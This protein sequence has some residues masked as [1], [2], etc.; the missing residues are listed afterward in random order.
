[1]RLIGD[2]RVLEPLHDRRG[3]AAVAT[4]STAPE[5]EPTFSASQLCVIMQS[6][7]LSCTEA[8]EVDDR[9][10]ATARRLTALRLHIT[11]TPAN[12]S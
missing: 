8:M 11:F 3:L 1:M 2:T 10:A 4:A 9:T 7:G 12:R 5:K 6:L